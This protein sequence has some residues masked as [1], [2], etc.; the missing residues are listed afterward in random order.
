MDVVDG[1]MEWVV[2]VERGLV[3][4]EVVVVVEEPIDGLGRLV[5]VESGRWWAGV[6]TI[7]VDL[8]VAGC[9]KVEVEW[10]V[11]V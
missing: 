6:E 11:D 3:V 10:V 1:E 2:V 8:K 9:A 4:V 7:V 5:E